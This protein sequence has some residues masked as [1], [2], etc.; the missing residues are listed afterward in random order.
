MSLPGIGKLEYNGFAF[1]GPMVNTNVSIENLRGDDDRAVIQQKITIDV[2]A[3]IDTEHCNELQEDVETT[4]LVPIDKIAAMLSQD[5]KELVYEDK[6]F[7]KLHINT[8]NTDP[9][10]LLDVDFGPRVKV[11]SIKPIASN[12]AFEISWSIE[13]TVGYCP[14]LDEEGQQTGEHMQNWDAGDIK[15]IVYTVDWTGD[16]KGYQTRRVTGFLEIVIEPGNTT[17]TADDYRD[18]I[19]FD[20]AEG[21]HRV[22]QNY[23][24]NKRRDRLD[25]TIVD[26][27]IR[28]QYAYPAGV[29]EFKMSHSV[30][31]GRDTAY[32]QSTS[33][34]DGSCEVANGFS[35]Y[36]AWARVLP[37]LAERLTAARAYSPIMVLNFKVTE[38]VFG[39]SVSFSMRYQKLGTSPSGFIR[40]AGL[41]ND[42]QT[43]DWANWKTSLDGIYKPLN[44]RSVGNMSF[45]TASD[46]SI[47]PCS[48]QPANTEIPFSAYKP[49]WS[50]PTMSSL[51][52]VLPPPEASYSFY[53]STLT[54][55]T[56]P[57]AGVFT[58][59]PV[60]GTSY[61]PT[62]AKSSD[63]VVMNP[64]LNSYVFSGAGSDSLS[65]G[66]MVE[67]E[68]RGAASRLGYAVEIPTVSSGYTAYVSKVPNGSA[69]KT[70][71]KNVLGQQLYMTAWSI[72]Y[73]VSQSLVD[74]A[75]SLGNLSQTL[76][77]VPSD[78]TGANNGT[79]G[80]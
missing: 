6:V 9:Y 15:Q 64:G 27:E 5:G 17:V 44:S 77:G 52:N 41:F 51:S 66:P 56:K 23:A 55:Y 32:Q 14:I 60:Y 72:R 54:V 2:H 20:H 11:H 29:V 65:V 43:T 24:L 3:F 30:E 63:G 4:L 80:P 25:F 78:P 47:T 71:T 35:T 67:L 40:S 69:I 42:V 7:H 50:K 73:L 46:I 76:F 10:Q 37:V 58:E 75:G 49:S 74:A 53:R 31:V 33:S 26:E 21:Y 38:D 79:T 22:T 59:M 8:G 19:G 18:R 16:E 39:R 70:E 13:T 36:H 12:R 45:D 68:F 57:G 34:I 28:S 61:S 62:E 48:P 1:N